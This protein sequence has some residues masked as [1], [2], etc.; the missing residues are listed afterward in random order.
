MI[1][2]D[3]KVEKTAMQLTPTFLYPLHPPPCADHGDCDAP[4][5]RGPPRLLADR[6]AGGTVHPAHVPPAVLL[7]GLQAHTLRVPGHK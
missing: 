1:S 7:T 4:E 2:M 3:F 6:P 5:P